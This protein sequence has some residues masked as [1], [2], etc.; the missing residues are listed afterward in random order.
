MKFKLTIWLTLLL[1]PGIHLIGQSPDLYPLDRVKRGQKGYGKTVFEGAT[2]EPFDVEILGILKNISPKQNLILARLSGDRLKKTGVFAGM[3]GSPVY[4]EDKLVGAVAYSF[5]FSTEPIAGITPI[6]E[7]LDIFEGKP[8]SRFE[9]GHKFSP[10]S[11]HEVAQISDLFR[12]TN[13]PNY[14]VDP[15]LTGGRD[16]GRLEAINTPLNLSGFSPQMT[17]MWSTQLHSLGLM[18]VRGLGTAEIYDVPDTPL[19]AGSTIVVQLL[20]GDL[21]ISASGTVTHL[22]GKKIYAFGHPFLSIGSTDLPLNKATVLTVIPSLMTSQKISAPTKLIGSIKQDR[23]TGILGM[24]GEEPQ[25]TPVKLRLHSARRDPQELNFEVV[26]DSFLT[27]FLLT[28]AVHNSIVSSERAVGAQSL[29][30]KLTVAVKGEQSVRF[31]NSVSDQ[32]TGP[33]AAALIAAAP[34]KFLLTSRFKDLSMERI[35]VEISAMEQ[36]RESLLKRIWLDRLEVRAGE[37]ITLSV[38]I[39]HSNGKS[40]IE[41]YP[42]KIP[43]EL[44][45]GPLKIIVSDGPSLDKTD[46]EGSPGEFIPKNLRQLIQAINNLKKNDRLY[47]RLARNHPGAIVAGEGMPDLPPSLLALYNSTKVSGAVLPITQVV[48]VDHELPATDFVMKGK[49]EISIIIK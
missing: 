27:P 42:I 12:T 23:A 22:A 10:T 20:R 45:S 19:Q 46:A 7:M 49:Q 2:V 41:K 32:S 29:E 17:N 16:L 43:E 36:A 25:L 48:Y 35:E 14:P 37:E 9:V 6:Q 44:S 4:I 28:M 8:K 47:I 33:V 39:Q 11:L 24:S 26:T 21:D 40:V 31:E 13:S 30:V 34:V 5:S 3:S 15:S 18:P 1:L 38:A